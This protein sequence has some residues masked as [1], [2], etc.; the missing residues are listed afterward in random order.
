MIYER[1]D[2]ILI[3]VSNFTVVWCSYETNCVC[4]RIHRTDVIDIEHFTTQDDMIEFYKMLKVTMGGVWIDH[5][6]GMWMTRIFTNMEQMKSDYERLKGYVIDGG[7][8]T[9]EH[10]FYNLLEED[11]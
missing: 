5:Y 8:T 4:G 2:G 1:N 11:K 6:T 10:P 3:N 7:G 9:E